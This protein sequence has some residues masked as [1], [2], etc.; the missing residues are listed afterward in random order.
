M[1]IREKTTLLFQTRL[2]S[3]T[4]KNNKTEFKPIKDS[5]FDVTVFDA[6]K[7]TISKD[8]LMGYSLK[9][10]KCH[11]FSCN[12]KDVKETT[13]SYQGNRIAMLI[14]EWFRN[15]PLKDFK[16]IIP[17]LRNNINALIVDQV[18]I[19]EDQLAQ[20]NVDVNFIED[21]VLGSYLKTTDSIQ[22]TKYE[23]QFCFD[24]QNAVYYLISNSSLVSQSIMIAGTNENYYKSI[25]ENITNQLENKS[26]LKILEDL[27][28][29]QVNK[30]FRNF[31]ANYAKLILLLQTKKPA[32]NWKYRN[33]NYTYNNLLDSMLIVFYLS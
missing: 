26:E 13:Y 1:L 11:L 8:F 10:G 2:E 16:N 17:D 4:V 23:H 3:V 18:K 31:F 7:W 5:L 20:E 15:L 28:N 9:E 25:R 14:I 32:Q 30:D 27:L 19:Y 29:E 21:L 24:N 33:W 12:P 22:L 6:F